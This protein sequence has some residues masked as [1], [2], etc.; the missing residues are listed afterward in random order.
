MSALPGLD[1]DRLAAWIANAVELDGE[2]RAELI[3]GGNSNLTFAVRDSSHAWIL[4]RP[5]VGHVLETAHDMA[6]EYRIIR[7]LQPTRVPV[8]GVVTLCSDP[9]VLGAPFYLME[10]AAGHAIRDVRE[11]AARGPERTRVIANELI[12]ALVALHAVDIASVGLQSFGR[13]EG[14]LSRQVARWKKQLDA[15]FTREL[16]T[17]ESLHA[18][19]QS[20]IPQSSASGIVHGDYRLDNVLVDDDDRIS[21][22]V[23]WEL[24]TL[25]DPL[26]DLALMVVYGRLGQA[27]PDVVPDVVGVR[28]YPSED[29]IITRYAAASSRDVSDFSFY[30]GL[31][32]FK[33][34]GILEGICHRALH[35]QTAGN[36]PAGFADAV[37][38]LLDGGL[39]ALDER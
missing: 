28:G 38:V 26:T 3:T 21:A 2:L 23:D 22:V 1:L 8:P 27:L 33:A 6:R 39:A 9:S 14:Y 12:D 11:L 7:A 15:S 5:P 30:V 32:S 36:V 17:A 24:A 34:A 20:R 18:R 35:G 31:A 25:G 10:R 13:P 4:R 29:E 16:P 19:L 37:L